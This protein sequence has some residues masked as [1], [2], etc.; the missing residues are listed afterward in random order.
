M[1]DIYLRIIFDKTYADI[2]NTSKHFSYE[3]NGYIV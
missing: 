3:Y 1:Y 2:K